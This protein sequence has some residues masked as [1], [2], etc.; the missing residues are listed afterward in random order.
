MLVSILDPIETPQD[1]ALMAAR[2]PRNLTNDYVVRR[3]GR[4]QRNVDGSAGVGHLD[5]AG[6][7]DGIRISGFWI[8][9]VE[10]FG[11]SAR[12]FLL[13]HVVRDRVNRHIRIVKAKKRNVLSV[14]REPES[15]W[16]HDFFFVDPVRYAVEFIGAAVLCYGSDSAVSPNMKIILPDEGNYIGISFRLLK[17]DRVGL[18]QLTWDSTQRI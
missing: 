5:Q 9:D 15:V 18:A 10:C 8:P 17:L 3:P 7:D 13:V 12:P 6:C 11:V 16:A 1:E 14:R 2:D 4:A